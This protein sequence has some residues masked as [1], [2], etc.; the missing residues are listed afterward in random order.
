MPRGRPRKFDED[1]ALDAA[2]LVFW[3]KGLAATSLDDLALGM[4]MNRPSI[5]NAFGNKES[6]YRAALARFTAAL[7][8]GLQQLLDAPQLEKG[9]VAF[10]DQAIDLY[11]AHSPPLGCLMICTA[12]DSAITH[13]NVGEDLGKM[14]R[15][16]DE[17]FSRRLQRARDDGDIA[18]ELKPLETAKLLQATLQTL[19][20]RARAGESRNSLRKLARFAVKV[21]L[22]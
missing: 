17:G 5:Y 8:E 22:G 3:E 20:I 21:L 19:A 7:D 13:P 6:I 10:Y 11:C 12:P 18:R 16:L 9:L 15:K 4:G 1:T 2:M 14:L